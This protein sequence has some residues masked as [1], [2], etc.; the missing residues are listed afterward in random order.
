MRW[1]KRLFRKKPHWQ[2]VWTPPRGMHIVG[3]PIEYRG[4]VVI[5]TTEGVLMLD[6]DIEV[7]GFVA[8]KVYS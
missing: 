8:R 5:A 2:V 1:L 3:G 6:P 7:N 4:Q